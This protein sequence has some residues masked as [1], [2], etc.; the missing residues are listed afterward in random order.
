VYNI[1][2][3]ITTFSK[4][5]SKRGKKMN[6]T[7][8]SFGK[9]EDGKAVDLFRLTNNSGLEAAI[10]TYGGIIVSLLVPDRQGNRA[11]IVLGFDKL[12]GYLRRHPYFGAL[13]GRYA[14]RIAQG[15]FFLNG[16]EYKL[17]QNN[18]PNHLHGGIKGFDKAVWQAEEVQRKEEV[19]L[20]LSYLSQD[21][22][23]GYPGNLAV[24]VLYTVTGQNDLKIDYLATTDQATILNLTNHS[25]FNLAGA[26]KGDI[27]NHE[28]MIN[29]GKFTPVNETLIPTGDLRPVTG[30]P[31]D[32]SQPLPIGAR[33]NNDD[34]QLQRAGGYDHNFV[35][36]TAGN[37]TEVAA[38]VHEPSTGRTL[39]LYTTQPGVQFYAGN[40]LDGSL[41]GKGGHIY[42]K[43]AGFCLETQHF[44]DSPNQPNFPS[45]VLRPGETYRQTTIYK[46]R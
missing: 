39:E 46:F 31:L 5:S 41:T 22:E 9:T 26:G 33:I 24:E 13:V 35:L 45:T 16:T 7:H 4:K 2:L 25:Y 37:L 18:G 10:T 29:A 40:F 19:G 12:D 14:N 6:L 21:G 28:V 42:H 43:R 1:L 36:N 30:T 23:E 17:A 38:R 20:K 34:D 44:P 32:F 11:D 3:T 27:L 15:K 8:Q